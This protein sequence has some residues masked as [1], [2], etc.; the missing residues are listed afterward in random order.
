[1]SAGLWYRISSGNVF[2]P[3]VKIESRGYLRRLKN[4][5]TSLL[6]Y[7]ESHT[8]KLH[9]W[10]EVLGLPENPRMCRDTKDGIRILLP[11]SSCK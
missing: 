5:Q 1:M 6:L 7:F 2:P 11:P 10:L 3:L 4:L 8:L 9:K